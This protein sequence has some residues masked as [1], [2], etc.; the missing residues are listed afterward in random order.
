MYLVIKYIIQE[1][2]E[3]LDVYNVNGERTNKSNTILPTKLYNDPI[4]ITSPPII[5]WIRF[6]T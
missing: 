6:I 4:Y 3:K 2:M 5:D 1:K